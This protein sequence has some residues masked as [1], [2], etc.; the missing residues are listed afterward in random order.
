MTLQIAARCAEYRRRMPQAIR[1]ADLSSRQRKK[2]VVG[3]GLRPTAMRA[4]DSRRPTWLCLCLALVLGAA[5][6]SSGAKPGA[7]DAAAAVDSGS[8]DDAACVSETL[9]ALCSAAGY[10]CGDATFTDRCG[11]LVAGSCGTCSSG[12]CGGGGGGH[13][14]SVPGWTALEWPSLPQTRIFAMWSSP[15]SS[16]VWA[17]GGAFGAGE[18]WQI[19][20]SGLSILDTPS[21]IA[22]VHAAG[23]DVWA[24]GN[25]GSV[26]HGNNGNFTLIP[27]STLQIYNLSAVWGFGPTDLWVT[28]A[29]G[30]NSVA[31][32][33]G[34]SWTLGML[35]ST[36]AVP[37]CT[38]L[39]AAAPD[40]LWTV[41]RGGEIFHW[42]GA[43]SKVASSTAQDLQAIYGFAANNIW[44]VG[45]SNTLLHWNG[46]AWGS[47]SAPAGGAL[48]G[49]WGAAA[50]D[51][52]AVGNTAPVRGRV[53]HFD[54]MA[55]T[56][57]LT[58]GSST[59]LDR[60]AGAQGHVF[61]AGIPALLVTY[62]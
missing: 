16:T 28:T 51:I 1:T 52:Y 30:V 62:P 24:V 26:V 47:V 6:G 2:L 29:N 22:G 13:V 54:G 44:A 37:A 38:G 23:A 59:E 35:P 55:W 57:V 20:G 15:G 48:I 60:V 43:W 36:A 27:S 42:N 53:I 32:W 50:N 7:I 39:W 21:T 9:Q 61:A 11:A 45:N 19:E 25:A 49:I 3:L 4:D 14:C 8:Q 5:C 46:S 18:L 40:D 34:M 58:T 41:C 31:H 56:E 10:T 17:G 12:T 33:N